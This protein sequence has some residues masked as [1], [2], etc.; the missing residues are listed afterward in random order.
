MSET[1]WPRY[2]VFHQ[3]Q[4]DRPH[5]NAGTV[6]APDA[7]MALQNARDVFVRRPDCHSLWVVRAQ[8]IHSITAQE[9]EAKDLVEGGSASPSTYQV[10]VKQNQIRSHE[11]LDTVEASSPEAA[12]RIAIERYP[13]LVWWVVDE[14]QI[15]RSEPDEV[16]SLFAPAE[17]KP[18]RSQSDYPTMTLMRR[19]RDR[20]DRSK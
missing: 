12:L 15:T 9:Q 1:Q 7:E 16:D 5:V 11:H 10:F 17:A 4:P 18:Y 20:A 2:Q 6:H 3:E 14:D 19:F 8:A 13:G